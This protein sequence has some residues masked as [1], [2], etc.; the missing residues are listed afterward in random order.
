MAEYLGWE[1]GYMHWDV[2]F[3]RAVRRLRDGG[4]SFFFGSSL[5]L[6]DYKG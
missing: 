5:F 6:Q 3:N 2:A 1:N 4:S